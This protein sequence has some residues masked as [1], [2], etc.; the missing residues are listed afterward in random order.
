MGRW[1]HG[2]IVA[3][4]LLLLPIA[5]PAADLRLAGDLRPGGEAYDQLADVAVLPD[6]SVIAV[7]S[8]FV[9]G[10]KT[11]KGWVVKASPEKT[12]DWELIFLEHHR[13][14]LRAVVALEDGDVLVAGSYWPDA[15][16]PSLAYVARLDPD[17]RPRWAKAY[18]GPGN[19]EGNDIAVVADGG[20]IVVGYTAVEDVP[21]PL[22]WALRIGPDG[23]R[24]WE[25]TFDSEPVVAVS[26][27][28]D[29]DVALVGAVRPE[30]KSPDLWVARL[31]SGG[32]LRW[33]QTFGGVEHDSANTVVGT[34]DNG[35]FVAGETLSEGAG[36]ADA[37]LLRLDAKGALVWQQTYGGLATD[38]ITAIDIFDNGTIAVT[39]TTQEPGTDNFDLW[40]GILDG[41]GRPVA[42]GSL[43]GNRDDRGLGL[44]AAGEGN[45]VV[46][47]MVQPPDQDQLIANGR[48]LFIEVR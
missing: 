44:A 45:F 14:K 7:G 31:G 38:R 29:G 39:G 10:S 30:G 42:M 4:C 46:S 48:I 22:G 17:G 2:L 3:M 5:A 16:S 11:L 26:R 40:A 25:T 34:A 36:G 47:G 20:A 24:Q 35:L 8:T 27:L 15:R 9:A 6:G 1:R 41:K 37:W 13:S 28:A 19:D 21:R 32:A 12:I 23:G 33:E 18:G 43:G